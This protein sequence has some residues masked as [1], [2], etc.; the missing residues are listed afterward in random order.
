MACRQCGLAR[1]LEEIAKASDI[2]KKRIGESYRL[3]LRELGYQSLVQKPENYVSKILNT[4][5]VTGK[6][7][8]LA[9]KTLRAAREA[10][11][12]SGRGPT[13]VAAAACYVASVL[14]GERITQKDISEMIGCTEVT[15][16]NRYKDLMERLMFEVYL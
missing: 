13:G 2:P 5:G 7:E 3:L 11:L 16:R 9:Y 8:E 6:T 15:I 4:L 10:R 14:T 1:T 12:T